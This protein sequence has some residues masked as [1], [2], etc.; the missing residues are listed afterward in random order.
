MSSTDENKIK[1]FEQ[2]KFTGRRIPH[3]NRD[4]RPKIIAE[5]H[6][7]HRANDSFGNCFNQTDVGNAGH[8]AVP[9]VGWTT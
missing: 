6:K 3:F 2:F 7:K 9:A 8:A 1:G 5:L 4:Y